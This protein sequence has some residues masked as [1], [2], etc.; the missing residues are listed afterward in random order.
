MCLFAANA[1]SRYSCSARGVGRQFHDHLNVAIAVRL[2]H[3]DDKPPCAA[4]N[5]AMVVLAAW[6]QLPNDPEL[7]FLISDIISSI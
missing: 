5:D 4:V 1:R 2:V 6:T 7:R 3:L